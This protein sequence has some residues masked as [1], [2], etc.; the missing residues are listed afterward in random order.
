MNLLH[1]KYAVE[2]ERARSITKAAENLYMVQP[3]LSRAIKELEESIGIT[4]FRRTSKGIVPTPQGEEF[5]SYARNILEQV[6]EIESLYKKDDKEKITFNISIPR[7]SYITHAFIKLV[8]GM[9]LSKDMEINYKETNSLRAINNIVQGN[10]TLG[11][12]R[13][14]VGFE[15]YFET[16]LK[17][18]HLK[19]ETIWEFEYL[20]LM[21]AAHPLAKRKKIQYSDLRDSIEIAHGDPYVPSMPLTEVKKTEFSDLINK[22]IFV[23]ERGSQFDLLCDIPKT[24]IWVSPIPAELIARYDLVQRRCSDA[25]RKYRDVLIYADNYKLTNLE[26][27]FVKELHKVKDEVSEVSYQ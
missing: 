24:Y 20:A 22:R 13:Y 7:A 16:M 18:K 11:I 2:V 26:E 17:E 15:D 21:S 12:I 8:A 3:N 23:Y 4:I 14:Q 6:E 1:L 5:L 25:K 19:G 10:Y 9:D 27:Q